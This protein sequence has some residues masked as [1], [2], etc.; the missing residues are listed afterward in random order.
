MEH[1]RLLAAERRKA[2]LEAMKLNT[3]SLQL[4]DDEAS[5]SQ[6]MC[7]SND[8]TQ[9][10]DSSDIFQ[11]NHSEGEGSTLMMETDH[12]SSETQVGHVKEL[13]DPSAEHLE[14]DDLIDLVGKGES[15]KKSTV[16]LEEMESYSDDT[17]LNASSSQLGDDEKSYSQRICASNDRIQKPDLSGIIRSSEPDGEE[18]TLMRETDHH[19]CV[20]E[21]LDAKELSNLNAEHLGLDDLIDLVEEDESSKNSTVALE[22]IRSHSD[23][24]NNGK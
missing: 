20:K 23:D 15:S 24:I 16:S 12:H 8:R 7:A 5:N 18:S 3:S 4:G 14:L 21:I 6:S 10:H 22:E 19:S 9:K 2:K 1:N 17:K 13:F 11:S